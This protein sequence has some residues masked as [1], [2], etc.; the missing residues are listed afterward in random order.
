MWVVPLVHFKC[1]IRESMREWKLYTKG[2]WYDNLGPK[3]AIWESEFPKVGRLTVMGRVEGMHQNC[4]GKVWHV[5]DTCW[6]EP[7]RAPHYRGLQ[8]HMHRL[9]DRP[10]LS[11]SCDTDTLH[12]PTLMW[13]VQCI[14]VIATTLRTPTMGKQKAET[15]VQWTARLERE[16]SEPLHTC[17]SL[18]VSPC[19]LEFYVRQFFRRL[20]HT[21][22][23]S[24]FPT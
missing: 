15:P 13:T 18:L 4:F 14:V 9:T 22:P 2:A 23:F 24:H 1:I 10:C 17:T 12:V 21:S 5:S 6:G 7:E 3:A 19:V 20:L 16:T 11:H 8:G